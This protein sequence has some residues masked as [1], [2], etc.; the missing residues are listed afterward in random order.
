[1]QHKSITA[2]TAVATWVIMSA[3][4][5]AQTASPT[6]SPEPIATSTSTA[7]GPGEAGASEGTGPPDTGGFD[8]SKLTPEQQEALRL[9]IIKTSENPIGNIT[10]LPFKNYF[11]YGVGPYTRYGYSLNVEPVVPIMLSHSWNLIARTIASIS[12]VPSFAPPG[13]CA[14][15]TGC[16]WTTGLDD[17]QEQF[18]FAPKTKPGQLI[19]GVGPVFQFPTGTPS[20]LSAG[21]WCIGPDVV[22]LMT[23]GK[24]VYGALFA[25]I[26]SFAGPASRPNVSSLTA[27]P[28]I[29][30]NIGHG[31]ALAT[32]PIITANFTA[33]QN[34]WAV[35]LGGGISRTF[36]AGNQLMSLQLQYY[37]YVTR[38]LTSPQTTLQFN[39]ALLWPVKRGINVEQLLEEAA[40]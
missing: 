15:P 25:Q 31:W 16:P 34:K 30:Y 32:S 3:R 7:P 40:H 35:P 4:V 24:W 37:T 21:K 23:P 22:V 36:K 13:V 28:F 10:V 8:V 5:V 39:A 9:L 17:T 11:N 6:A 20:T 33:A 1:M 19:W 14:S 27:E 29:D 18:F 2:L 26:W 12:S 38:P